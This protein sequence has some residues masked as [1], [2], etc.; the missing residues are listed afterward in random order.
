LR[1]R[2]LVPV[3]LAGFAA[4]CAAWIYDPYTVTLV[5]RDTGA[6]GVGQAPR[7][8]T[9]GGEVAVTLNGRNFSGEWFHIP[10]DE[11]VLVDRWGE[12]GRWPDPVREAEMTGTAEMLLVAADD[13]KLRCQLRFNRAAARGTGVCNALDGGFYDL[14]FAAR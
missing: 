5:D 13:D 6:T 4:G 12:P 9:P 1:F 14:R 11:A 8:W 7:D 2:L 10:S 3:L